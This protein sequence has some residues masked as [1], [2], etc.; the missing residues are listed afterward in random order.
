MEKRRV[1]RFEN[2]SKSYNT[3]SDMLK[4]YRSDKNNV[5]YKF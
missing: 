3:L 2:F 5:A 1:Q 4:L